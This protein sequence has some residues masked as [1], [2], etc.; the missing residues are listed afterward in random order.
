M[1]QERLAQLRELQ[2]AL[3]SRPYSTILRLQ[4]A[5]AYRELGYPDL[6]AG[7]AY[8]ALLLL[9][10][11][12]EGAEY[13]DETLSAAQIDVDSAHTAHLIEE[14]GQ[15]LSGSTSTEDADRW[16]PNAGAKAAGEESDAFGQARITWSETAYGEHFFVSCRVSADYE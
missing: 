3:T 15:H 2:Q 9:D 8:K 6:A 10:E 1:L 7:D 13:H 12:T 5:K 11:L 16:V 14:I 4:L